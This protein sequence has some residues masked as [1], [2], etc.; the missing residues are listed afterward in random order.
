MQMAACFVQSNL[1]ATQFD[2]KIS[3]QLN[4]NNATFENLKWEIFKVDS[5]NI[6]K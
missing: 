1:G 4:V 3:Q 6:Q 2:G 5:G